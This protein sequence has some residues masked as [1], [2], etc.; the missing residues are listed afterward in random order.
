MPTLNPELNQ[1][2]RLFYLALGADVGLVMTHSVV[3][4]L[5][6]S[7]GARHSF[8][9]VQWPWAGFPALG[10]SGLRRAHFS[11]RKSNSSTSNLIE[12]PPWLAQQSKM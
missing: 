1:L 5:L 6:D 12:E 8:F 2:L 3:K 9:E 11:N 4:A 10:S 7:E